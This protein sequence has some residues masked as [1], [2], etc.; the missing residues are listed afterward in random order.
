MTDDTYMG[1]T[2]SKDTCCKFPF[3]VLAFIC[4]RPRREQEHDL[5]IP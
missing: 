2:H 5:Q 3:A 4:D 1:Q